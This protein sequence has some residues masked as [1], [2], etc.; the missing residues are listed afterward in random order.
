MLNFKKII[1]FVSLHWE[2]FYIKPK[3]GNKIKNII[4]IS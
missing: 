1:V 4:K 3:N 2:L